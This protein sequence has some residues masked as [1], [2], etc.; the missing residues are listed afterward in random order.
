MS[1]KIVNNLA[2]QQTDGVTEEVTDLLFTKVGTD[3]VILLQLDN[4]LLQEAFENG[5]RGCFLSLTHEA[6]IREKKYPSSGVSERSPTDIS[7]F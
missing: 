1:V 2:A 7:D 4:E 6:L 3:S 5:T